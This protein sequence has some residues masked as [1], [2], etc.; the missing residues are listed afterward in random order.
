MMSHHPQLVCPINKD[1]LFTWSQH[2][3]RRQETHIWHYYDLNHRSHSSFVPA[4]SFLAK[5]SISALF[6]TFH[7]QFSCNSF[8]LEQSSSLLTFMTLTLLKI[9]GQLFCTM[10]FNLN[11]SPVTLYF[12]SGYTFWAELSQKWC[13]VNFDHLVIVVFAI[14][15]H[16]KTILFS[17]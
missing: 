8:N 16:S 14:F 12:D 15:C 11:L 7:S 5:G 13:S 6:S 1:I 10:S 4:T 3:H 9:I 2:Q 17:L